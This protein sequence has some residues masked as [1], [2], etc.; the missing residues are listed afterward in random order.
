VRRN[1]RGRIG[2]RSRAGGKGTA[3]RARGTSTEA[4]GH[5]ATGRRAARARG[6]QSARAGRRREKRAHREGEGKGERKEEGGG[7]S[8]PRVQIRRSPSPKPR[9]PRGRERERWRRGGCCAGKLNERKGEKG[10]GRT[11]GGVG[12]RGAWARAGP[13]WVASRVKIPRH[14]QPLIGIQTRNEKRNE[15]RQT[16]D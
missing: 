10:G 7:K 13:S 14:A 1:A 9:V 15:T 12:A 8:S 3:A 4:R 5:G 2:T 6:R 16:R 11:W